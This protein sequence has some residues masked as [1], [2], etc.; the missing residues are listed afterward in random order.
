[1]LDKLFVRVRSWLHNDP[2]GALDDPALPSTR[3]LSGKR[4]NSAKG[5]IETPAVTPPPLPPDAWKEAESGMVITESG[6]IIIDSNAHEASRAAPPR[7]ASMVVPA[8]SA[9]A[10]PSL[11]RPGAP[12]PSPVSA[13]V[14]S[15]S[16][17]PMSSSATTTTASN[18]AANAE[19]LN[20]DEVLARAK[21]RISAVPDPLP[22]TPPKQTRAK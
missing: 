14:T 1:M 5:T 21:A 4:G 22:S 17:S 9:W 15:P 20:W 6:I 7:P 3:N 11:P 19:S 16:P 12:N 13:N 8:D 18:R 10:L 2:T